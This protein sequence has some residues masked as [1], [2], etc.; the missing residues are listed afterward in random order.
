MINNKNSEI[1]QV[2]PLY[3]VSKPPNVNMRRF[4]S[5]P[6]LG[7]EL[8]PLKEEN[9]STQT[10]KEDITLWA[11]IDSQLTLTNENTKK[12]RKIKNDASE[13]ICKYLIDN[14][15]KNKIKIKCEDQMA[16]IKMY[17]KKEYSAL[18]FGYIEAC[19]NKIIHDEEQVNYVID[20]L[21]DNRE[22]TSSPD[23]MIKRIVNH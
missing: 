6:T 1:V 15:I 11:L 2:K 10:F 21:K 12:M 4:L 13:R 18:S 7:T 8:V 19:L 22:I 3:C 20:F 16:E 5:E 17:D 23:I 9:S 14:K